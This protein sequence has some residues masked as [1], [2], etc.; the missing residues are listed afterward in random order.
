MEDNVRFY[1]E[2]QL[3]KPIM[4]I[5][6]GGWSNA[7]NSSLKSIDYII[8][9]K[10]GTLLA[11]IDPDSFYQ[12]TQNRPII[13]IEEGRLKSISQTEITIYYSK[14]KEGGKDIIFLRAQE[15]DYRWNNF[16]ETILNLCKKWDVSLMI[17]LG[18]MYDDVLHTESIISGVYSS[19]EWR[20]VFI[21]NDISMINYEG[22]SGIHSLIM[23]KTKERSYPFF[24]LWGHTPLYLRGTN[25]RVVIQ[26]VNLL[27][28]LFSF[29]IETSEL[30]SS[31]KEFEAQIEGILDQND[32]LKEHIEEIK[33][34]RAGEVRKR[35][36]P[37]VVNI[38]D[39]MRPNES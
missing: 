22:P 27:A 5:G 7:G 24:G 9:K 28:S 10:G 26:I 38:K 16:V 25:F 31:L 11:K 15:P 1:K 20:D 39:F 30:D 13:A 8:E 23:E 4:I 18:G 33:K 29:S 12:F 35:G 32:E 6:F 36:T 37:K 21:K 34:M 17:S 2:P 3:I 14:N 19:E